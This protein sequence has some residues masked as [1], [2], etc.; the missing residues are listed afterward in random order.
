MSLLKPPL[1]SMLFQSADRGFPSHDQFRESIIF[2]WLVVFHVFHVENH[3]LLTI[4]VLHLSSFLQSIYCLKTETSSR[5]HATCLIVDS[6]G[7]FVGSPCSTV[8]VGDSRVP[9][10]SVMQNLSCPIP[11]ASGPSRL[12]LPR[13]CHLFSTCFKWPC[14]GNVPRNIYGFVWSV[15]LYQ[16][17]EIPGDVCCLYSELLSGSKLPSPPPYASQGPSD[18]IP[19]EKPLFRLGVFQR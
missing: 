13:L 18:I 2:L 6:V 15:P 3:S 16:R 7:M 12:G 4:R 5:N 10:T 1:S 8:V 11:T 17:P 9:M 19:Y 14:Q